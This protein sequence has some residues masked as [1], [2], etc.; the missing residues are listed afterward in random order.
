MPF[1]R[2][3]FKKALDHLINY[4]INPQP[5]KKLLHIDDISDDSQF[6]PQQ[7]SRKSR[8]SIKAPTPYK[9]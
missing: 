7:G 6:F 5:N 3:T 9:K 1:I 8:S 4:K 2:S